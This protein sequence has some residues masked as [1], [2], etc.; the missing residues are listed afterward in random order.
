M[1]SAR[2]P[3]YPADPV[4]LPVLGTTTPLVAAAEFNTGVITLGANIVIIGS[5][6]ADEGGT[7][8]IEQSYD[9]I[10]WDV[11]T[12]YSITANDGKGF[13]EEIVADY[14]QI[15]YVNGGDDQT[16]FRIHISLRP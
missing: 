2:V 7:L 4:V 9:A 14:A 13:S 1:T 15:R 5:V 3:Y 6:F 10:N 16:E 12:S 11:S 8:Y